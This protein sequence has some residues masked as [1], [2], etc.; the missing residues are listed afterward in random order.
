MK[1]AEYIGNFRPVTKEDDLLVGAPALAFGPSG[2]MLDGM[3]RRVGIDDPRDTNSELYYIAE[4]VA[5]RK[6][7]VHDYSV[8]I[9]RQLGLVSYFDIRRDGIPIKQKTDDRPKDTRSPEELEAGVQ[10]SVEA[11]QFMMTSVTLQALANYVLLS[12]KVK[13]NA[14]AVQ[15]IGNTQRE[16][17]AAFAITADGEL[18][19]ER[20]FI[21]NTRVGPASVNFLPA[22]DRRAPKWIEDAGNW[23]DGPI[24]LAA[25]HH[26]E[27]DGLIICREWCK[28]RRDGYIPIVASRGIDSEQYSRS[29]R[30]ANLQADVILVKLGDEPDILPVQMKNIINEDDRAN[31]DPRVVMMSA[32]DM[33]GVEMRSDKVRD[34][35]GNLCTGS[36]TRT[37]IGQISHRY[38]EAVHARN[39]QKQHVQK[40]SR[41]T[42]PQVERMDVLVAKARE[43]DTQ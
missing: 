25:G 6:S 27:A 10:S 30:E 16:F 42:Q 4:E 41:S 19:I 17:N 18:I 8:A 24:D 14:A 34:R 26:V 12:P 21:G 15:A 9:C 43:A 5:A 39:N 36:V 3:L 28:A 37:V 38:N 13:A 22:R 11:I 7:L 20:A 31:Y 29:R 2:A 33:G 1:T 40:F 32:Q 35:H 23:D